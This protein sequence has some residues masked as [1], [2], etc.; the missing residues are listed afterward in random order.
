LLRGGNLMLIGRIDRRAFVAGL[1]SA[2]AWPVVARSQQTERVRRIGML[3]IIAET[4]PQAMKN[5]EAFLKQ[6]HQLGWRA[7]DNVRIDHRSAPANAIRQRAYAAEL[8]GLAPDLIVAEGT[9]GLVAA[10]LATR[11][12]PI[13]FVNVSDPVGQGF[14]ESLARPGGNATGFTLFEFSMGGQ[15]GWIYVQPRLC[16]VLRAI[17][18]FDPTRCPHPRVRAIFNTGR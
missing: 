14:I 4:D 13:I 16:T 6:L 12:V 9:P 11:T 15:A 5:R 8:I 3:W 2:A 18:S 1:G 17:S 7:G 10:Q